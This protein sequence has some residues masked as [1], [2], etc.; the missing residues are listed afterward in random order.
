MNIIVNP[1]ESKARI[2]Y[3]E[4]LI[5]VL[6]YHWYDVRI[7]DAVARAV[8]NASIFNVFFTT[9]LLMSI[10]N[11]HLRQNKLYF[12]RA[13]TR[14]ML[15]QQFKTKVWTYLAEWSLTSFNRS[16]GFVNDNCMII[17][18]LLENIKLFK[19]GQFP[20][21]HFKFCNIDKTEELVADKK[22]SK[23]L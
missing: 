22:K 8:S 3:M 10:Q 14:G 23:I 4:L 5:Y 13:P 21:K 9:L 15:V 1:A 11:S 19:S 7:Y 12:S 6:G 16:R 20:Y 2:S 18:R 17:I